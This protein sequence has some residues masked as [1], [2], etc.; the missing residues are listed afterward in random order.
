MHMRDIYIR[1]Y[2]AL[3]QLIPQLVFLHEDEIKRFIG[4][5]AKIEAVEVQKY[6]HED[7]CVVEGEP[8]REWVYVRVH[9]SI[10]GNSLVYDIALWKLRGTKIWDELKKYG[11][12]V[13]GG[14]EERLVT[15]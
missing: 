3:R 7:G 6:E 12:I 9:Y 8:T 10:Y 13:D 14:D 5:S 2:P 4:S 15:V 11:V 1:D